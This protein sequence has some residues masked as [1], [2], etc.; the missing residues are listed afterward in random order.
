M[1]IVTFAEI[2]GFG[3]GSVSTGLAE[4]S[5]GF[6]LRVIGE[7][8]GCDGARRRR[9]AAATTVSK[10]FRRI[11]VISF[12]QFFKRAWRFINHV[13]FHCLRRHKRFVDRNNALARI[14]WQILRRSYVRLSIH[15]ISAAE[16]QKRAQQ[17]A[18]KPRQQSRRKS[19]MNLLTLWPSLPFVRLMFAL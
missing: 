4:V 13:Y 8:F 3:N 11:L 17:S 7:D 6:G 16:R 5:T 9:G 15:K 18:A 2:T 10:N 1:L 14:L 12:F 19:T